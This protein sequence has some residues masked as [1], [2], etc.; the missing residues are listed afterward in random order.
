MRMSFFDRRKV[1]WLIGRMAG[2]AESVRLGVQDSL[3]TSLVGLGQMAVAGLLMA[4]CDPVLFLVIA[5]SLPIVW[6]LN[7]HF[8]SGLSRLHREVH[9]SFSRVTTSLAEAVSYCRPLSTGARTARNLWI[10]SRDEWSS[11]G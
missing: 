9:E 1:G 3:F 6:A 4:V 11:I 7:R 10:R 2:D 5:A 8:R